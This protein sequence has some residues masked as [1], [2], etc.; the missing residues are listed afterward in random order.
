MLGL[1]FRRKD[2]MSWNKTALS[3]LLAG[4]ILLAALANNATAQA[5]VRT[6]PS[7][8]PGATK[9]PKLEPCWQVAGVSKSAVQQR[10]T[11]T[12]Q[13]HQEV[14]A[15]CTNAS[16]ST[17]QKRTEIQQIHQRERGQ[18][19]AV[20]TPSQQEAMR[21]CQESRN[22]GHGGG[23]AGTGHGGPCGEMSAQHKAN[24]QHEQDED[25]TSPNETP[26]PN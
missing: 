5:P 11:L 23:H 21:S 18:I 22:T 3:T 12:Q 7:T 9:K 4:V 15:V 2:F 8:P 17:Q 14:E 13:A 24:P 6:F 16:L 10:R 25:E 19:D 1:G 26:R 20:I